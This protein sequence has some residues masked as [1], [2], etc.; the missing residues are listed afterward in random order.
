[1]YNMNMADG[2]ILCLVSSL[3]ATANDVLQTT[4][5]M[6]TS[7]KHSVTYRLPKLCVSSDAFAT[8]LFQVEVF[9]VVTPCRAVVGYLCFRGPCC[10]C[11]QVCFVC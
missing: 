4:F 11:L 2:R 5:C 3:T 9:W 7:H 1:M 8:V 10:L 6:E